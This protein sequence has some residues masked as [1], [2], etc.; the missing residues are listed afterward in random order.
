VDGFTA[1]VAELDASAQASSAVADGVRGIDLAACADALTAALP[2]SRSATAAAN[3]AN[4]WRAGTKAAA[5]G[6]T[7]HATALADTARDYRAADVTVSQ[8]FAG[9]TPADRPAAVPSGTA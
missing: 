1:P 4:T 6:L 3:T 5:D 7:A 2:G 9:P 8:G